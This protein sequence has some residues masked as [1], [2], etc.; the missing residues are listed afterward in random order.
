[1]GSEIE[2]SK[3]DD[4]SSVQAV[5]VGTLGVQKINKTNEIVAKT[6]NNWLHNLAIHSYRPSSENC[7]PHNL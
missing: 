3:S 7:L 2:V 1:M 6:K 4:D 5:D